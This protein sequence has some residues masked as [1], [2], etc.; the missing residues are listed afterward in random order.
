M[1]SRTGR[2]VAIKVVRSELAEDPAFRRRFEREVAAARS[3]SA[4]YTAAVVDAD[5]TAT[6][7]WLATVYIDGPSL[8]QLAVEH[9][10]MRPGAVLTLA[11]GLAEALAAIHAAGL[12]HRDLKP[13]NVI[14]NDVGPHIIDFGIVLAPGN[15]RMTSSLMVGTPS[16]V[17]PEVI[18]GEDAGPAG[19]VFALGATLAFAAAGRHLIHEGTMHAQ[20][21]R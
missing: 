3:V 7:P 8:S 2:R 20:M 9:G 1:K 10:P 15:T 19:D 21:N 14:L 6:E 18:R 17:P 5:T 13:G 12:V 16:Y 4:L 11:A